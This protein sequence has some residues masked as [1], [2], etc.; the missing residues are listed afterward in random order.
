MSLSWIPFTKVAKVR[1]MAIAYISTSVFYSFF[2]FFP[3]S[4]S[5]APGLP[6]SRKFYCHS[7]WCCPSMFISGWM[8]ERRPMLEPGL[9]GKLDK[10]TAISS[11][12]CKARLKQQWVTFWSLVQ[13]LLLPP[14]AH[15]LA[16]SSCPLKC[17]PA[18]QIT[19]QHLCKHGSSESNLMKQLIFS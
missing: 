8:W 16:Q 11:V 3:S 19:R 7:F 4:C 5:K 2:F 18:F 10:W 14:A 9:L 15:P 13:C 17:L 6:G 12:S 1:R